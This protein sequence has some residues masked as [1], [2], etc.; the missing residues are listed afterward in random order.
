MLRASGKRT[1]RPVDL[2]SIVDITTDPLLPAGRELLAFTDAAVLR[3]DDEMPVAR[4]ALRQLVGDAGVVRAAACA[5][6]FEMMNRLLDAIGVPVSEAGIAL[7]DGLGLVV[8]RHLRPADTFSDR[9]TG[10]AT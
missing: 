5:G 8:P 2:G 1:Q 4:E 9:T 6:N 10:P 7:A 3:D